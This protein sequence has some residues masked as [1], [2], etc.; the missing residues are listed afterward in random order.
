MTMPEVWLRGPVAGYAA[1]LQPVAHGLLQLREEAAAL[2]AATGD[3]ALWAA[4][5][6]CAS[7]GFH[8]RHGV[9]ALDRLFTY[10]RGEALSEEQRAALA[11]EPS[12]DTAPGAVA[13][14]RAAF[15]AGV[16][17]ALAQLRATDP[18][19]LLDPREVGRARLPSTVIGLLFHGA[20]HLQRHVGQAA[21]TLKLLRVLAPDAAR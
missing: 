1:G 17:R 8:L 18:A 6:G 9:G 5:G 3:A 11:A 4:P 14:A 7:A 10:A 12:P 19:T 16:D 21:T 15:E 20:E 13:R 2:L